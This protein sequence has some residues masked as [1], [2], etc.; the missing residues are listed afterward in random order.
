MQDLPL[1]PDA[2]ATWGY[3]VVVGSLIAF[4]A[5]L[6]LLAHSTPAVAISYVFVNPVIAIFLGALFARERVTTGEWMSCGVILIG[7][8]LIFRGKSATSRGK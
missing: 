2:V 7:V 8:I 4:G 3:L 6:F 1:K 5:N